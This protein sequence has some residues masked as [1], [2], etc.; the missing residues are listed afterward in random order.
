MVLSWCYTSLDRAAFSEQ[1]LFIR[2]LTLG[3]PIKLGIR[4][5]FDTYS[6]LCWSPFVFD[7]WAQMRHYSHACLVPILCLSQCLCSSSSRFSSSNS[8]APGSVLHFYFV[9][10][11]TEMNKG[12]SNNKFAVFPL[13]KYADLD[14][15][16]YKFLYMPDYIM[17]F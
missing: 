3:I 16:S 15:V 11:W 1:K 10:R 7:C 14:W 9:C 12:K 2:T 17:V 5:T 6:L 4:N 8:S 13:Y